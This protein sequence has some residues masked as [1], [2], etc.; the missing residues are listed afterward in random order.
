MLKPIDIDK[1]IKRSTSPSS[2][3]TWDD[4]AV[5]SFEGAVSGLGK[6]NLKKLLQEHGSLKKLSTLS[7]S[8]LYAKGSKCLHSAQ[9]QEMM[10][11]PI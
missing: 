1:R 11:T 4:C 3:K 6:T 7:A 2:N 9:L 10:N 5:R 8:D